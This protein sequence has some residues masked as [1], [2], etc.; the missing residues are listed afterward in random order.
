MGTPLHH[1]AV[2]GG[3]DVLQALLAGGAE[4][5]GPD[6][7]GFTP[8]HRCCQEEPMPKSCE[9]SPEDYRAK[10]D[11]NKSQV[12]KMLL[13]KG[14]NVNARE[15]KGQQTPL[16]LAAMNGLPAV[17]AVLLQSRADP[18]AINKIGQTPLI[19]AVIEQHVPVI[20]LLLAAGADVNFGN[21]LHSDWA[22]IHWAALTDNIKVV[23]AVLKSDKV[24]NVKDR[25]GRYPAAL[26]R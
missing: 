15:S 9:E 26:A 25:S 6:Q 14:A 8:L 22:A 18:G 13:D 19:Y 5:L 11:N 2:H 20:D 1:G 4:A 3:Q 16:H 17:A 23:D 10:F 24:R 7:E 12:A 21:R